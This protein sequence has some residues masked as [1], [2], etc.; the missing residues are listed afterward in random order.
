LQEPV[1]IY[2]W[3]FSVF[4]D[5]HPDGFVTFSFGIDEEVT[6]LLRNGIRPAWAALIEQIDEVA[7]KEI[8][9]ALS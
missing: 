9:D 5:E 8:E 3:D 1:R 2:T 7:R 6:R 4:S